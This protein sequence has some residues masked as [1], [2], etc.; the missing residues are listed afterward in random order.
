MIPLLAPHASD[1]CYE[2]VTRLAASRSTRVPVRCQQRFKR[3]CESFVDPVTVLGG[4]KVE[5]KSADLG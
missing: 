3:D 5:L 1:A 4:R 2:D